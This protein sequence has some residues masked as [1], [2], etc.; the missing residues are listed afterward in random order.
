MA[1]YWSALPVGAASGILDAV[2][3]HFLSSVVPE[4]VP[5]TFLVLAINAPTISRRVAS[6]I[7]SW[8]KGRLFASR[9]VLKY[10]T[11][12][13]STRNSFGEAWWSRT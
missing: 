10:K 11:R 13:L 5:S 9:T 8:A 3:K 6:L 12:I 4:Y 2:L 1:L 7:P